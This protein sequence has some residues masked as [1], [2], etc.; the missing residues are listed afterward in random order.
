MTTTVIFRIVFNLFTGLGKWFE[1]P[2]FSDKP[3][4]ETLFIICVQNFVQ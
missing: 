1:K 2:W 3:V 4:S